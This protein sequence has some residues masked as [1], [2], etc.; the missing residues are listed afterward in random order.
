MFFSLNGY[1]IPGSIADYPYAGFGVLIRVAPLIAMLLMVTPL[2]IADGGEY[3]PWLE[4]VQNQGNRDLHLIA[5][6]KSWKVEQLSSQRPT[7]EPDDIHR[8]EW[9]RLDENVRLTRTTRAPSM[10]NKQWIFERLVIDQILGIQ[11][12]GP[13]DD[14]LSGD[15]SLGGEFDTSNRREEFVSLSVTLLSARFILGL[16]PQPEQPWQS[17]PE[18]L[19]N[20][21]P[22]IAATYSATPS[23]QDVGFP[24]EVIQR[25]HYVS[26]A[27]DPEVVRSNPERLLVDTHKTE[28]WETVQGITYPKRYT[29]RTEKNQLD[30]PVKATWSLVE[31]ERFS[32]FAG[33]T[34]ADFVPSIPIAEGT[35]V[36]VNDYPLACEWREGKIQPV[37]TADTEV[38]P[39]AAFVYTAKKDWTKMFLAVGIIG[40]AAVVFLVVR[41]ASTPGSK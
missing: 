28:Q 4:S 33:L 6:V 40:I 27:E 7:R 26:E 13:D 37:I 22:Q 9:L 25:W 31:V 20:P 24:S 29:I 12:D 1:S 11:G 35:P 5:T 15:I 41:R 23:T 2:T 30:N 3:G 17:I 36:T 10:P 19:E 32:P 38:A 14:L 21:D 16:I 18:H 39:T 8:F 34:P